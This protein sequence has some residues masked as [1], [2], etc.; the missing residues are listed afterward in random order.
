M[1]K[2]VTAIPGIAIVA[3]M[4]SS[5]AWGESS[6]VFNKCAS[7]HTIEAGA[8]HKQ[9]PNLFGIMDQKAGT[10]AG[11]RY[12]K[13]LQTSEIIWTEETLDAFLENPRRTIRGNR[14]PFLGI[15]SAEE[16]DEILAY[17]FEVTSS[18]QTLVE[19]D[20]P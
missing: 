4:S 1:I 19:E 11:F 16:R 3:A 12:S 13:A 20:A 10:Q 7:C 8:P 5:F 17:M 14:M 2:S 15:K 18:A 6:R 9:G